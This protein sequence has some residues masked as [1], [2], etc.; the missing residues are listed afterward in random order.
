LLV[1][2]D[3]APGDGEVVIGGEQGDQAEGKATDGLGETE[4]I[5]SGPR[6]G[7]CWQFWRN[8]RLL[9]A[10]RRLGGA[11]GRGHGAGAETGG[12]GSKG[13][14]PPL[15][16]IRSKPLLPL[17]NQPSPSVSWRTV[18]ASKARNVC[19]R[20]Q[21][22]PEGSSW[23]RPKTQPPVRG[24]QGFQLFGSVAMASGRL[25]L[26]LFD[27]MRQR[28]LPVSVKI[29]IFLY[30]G[31]AEISFTGLRTCRGRCAGSPALGHSIKD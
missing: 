12:G 22:A 4:A 5:K 14:M 17:R 25:H 31:L 16:S 15:R 10:G 21:K 26:Q 7:C 3:V 1:D 2:G 30:L 27:E 13:S 6:R 11:G 8:R 24:V 29:D 9:A 23:T 19:H 28:S 20:P 18:P